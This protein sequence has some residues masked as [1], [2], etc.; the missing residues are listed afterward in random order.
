M[1]YRDIAKQ[2]LFINIVMDL[3]CDD[4]FNELSEYADNNSYVLRSNFY[5]VENL[6]EVTFTVKGLAD[7]AKDIGKL[8]EEDGDK[9]WVG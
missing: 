3:F 2:K 7:I 8:L 6:D 5:I 4:I 1:D 9:W